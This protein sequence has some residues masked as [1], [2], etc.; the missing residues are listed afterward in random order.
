[1]PAIVTNVA[2]GCFNLIDFP[3]AFEVFILVTI[4]A[5]CV[6]LAINT[7]YPMNDSDAVNVALVSKLTFIMI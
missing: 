4:F 6:A 3:R 5:N 7:P 2:Y 1:M